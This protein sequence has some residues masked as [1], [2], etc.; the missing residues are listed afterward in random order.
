MATVKSEWG[1]ALQET[2]DTLEG[3]HMR[4][5]LR[6]SETVEPGKIFYNGKPLLNFSSNDYLGLSRH[7]RVVESV[8]QVIQH[9]G[10]G[11]TSSRLIGGT[12]IIH[13]DLEAALAA[14]MQMESALIFPT[15]YMAN[16]GVITSLVGPGDAVIMDR[17]CHASIVDGARLSGARL[18]VYQHCDAEEA[19]RVLARTASYRRRLLIT[20]SLFSMDG[21]FAPLA[22][23]AAAGER[24]GAIRLVDEAH[25]LGVWGLNGQGVREAAQW[26]VVIGT[27][28]KALGSQGGFVASSREVIE[29]L[30]NNARTFIF[31][32]G[33]SPV[34]VAGAHAALSIVQEDEMLRQRVIGLATQLRDALGADGWDT[35]GSQS[36]IVP[37]FLGSAERALAVAEKLQ[38]AGVFAPAIRPPT[39]HAGQCRVRFSVT[40]EHTESDLGKVIDALK[41]VKEP[42]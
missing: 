2:L 30:V 23:I 29:T 41:T 25:A 19:E 36:Q 42:Q 13:Q 3:Q 7:P 28:S 39:V 14:F 21:D 9:W 12:S 27:L 6:I 34:S 37:V 18:F 4:R 40:A 5:H 24:Y 16:V 1:K 11:A 10:I 35:L 38:A 15:G 32:T 22:E 33:L 17:L 31:T 26:D 20:E 8:Q